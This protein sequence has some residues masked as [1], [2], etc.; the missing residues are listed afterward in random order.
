MVIYLCSGGKVA[1]RVIMNL[2]LP[3]Q[4]LM[5]FRVERFVAPPAS[6]AAATS[7]TFE[8][9]QV[10]VL[11]S[12]QANRCVH[13]EPE[14]ELSINR[15]WSQ[16]LDKS[17]RLF[18]GSKFRLQ[19]WTLQN[20]ML[21]MRWGLTDYKTYLG[22]CCSTRLPQWLQDAAGHGRSDQFAYLSRKVGV[23]AVLETADDQIAFIRRSETVGI[24]PNMFDTP[25]GHP[26]PSVGWPILRSK[27]LTDGGLLAYWLEYGNI[28]R[29]GAP[30]SRGTQERHGDSGCK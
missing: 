21:Q 19:Q 18:N 11:L 22:T 20:N 17:P 26:E 24:Y 9:Q 10:R 4:R 25:G 12:S 2:R 23:A 28:D 8:S 1:L 7:A 15:I 3:W 30:R 29:T 13:P 14:T 5:G 27:R 16:A 6:A